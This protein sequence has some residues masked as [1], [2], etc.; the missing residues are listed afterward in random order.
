MLHCAQKCQTRTRMQKLENFSFSGRR[1]IQIA[2]W[3]PRWNRIPG[4]QSPQ[5][6]RYSQARTRKPSVKEAAEKIPHR[7][8]TDL[9]R[10]LRH[11]Q[12]VSSTA[13]DYKHQLRDTNSATDLSCSFI[14]P[15][16]FFFRPRSTDAYIH[17]CLPQRATAL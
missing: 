9:D 13:D 2:W 4:K 15:A 1:N 11:F 3:T 5:P 6:W 8:E 12:W 16:P 14:S 10:A 7:E 17:K